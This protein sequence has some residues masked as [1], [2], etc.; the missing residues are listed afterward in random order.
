[1]NLPQ[2]PEPNPSATG[3]DRIRNIG[4]LAHVDAGKTS[5]TEKMLFLTGLKRETGAVDEGTTATDYLAV[6]R[7]HGIT[8]KSAAVRFDWK[9]RAIHLIDTPGHV[10]FGNEV[11]RALR[12]LDGAVIALCAVS[13]VQARTE[14]ISRA[15]AARM[16]PRLYFINKM[17]RSGAD[18]LGVV[19]DLRASLEPDTIAFQS[20]LFDGQKWVGFIDLISMKV[21]RFGATDAGLPF[22]QAEMPAASREAAL[23]ARALLLEKVAEADEE[24]LSLYASDR[25]ISPES[26]A[27]AAS[28]ATKA[29]RLV[30]VFCGSAFVDSSIAC[31]LDAVVAFLP[32]PAEASIPSGLDPGGNILPPMKATIAPPFAAFVF[33]T[34]RD[35]AGNNYAWAR[36]WSGTLH[37]GKKCFE[38]RSTKD[39]I[40]RKIFGIHAESLIELKEAGPGEVVALRTQG[41]ESGASLCERSFPIL[42]EALEIPVPVVSLVMEPASLEDV[43]AIRDALETL[44]LEDL[45]LRLSE[46]KETGRFEV[47]GQGELHLDIVAERLKR[48]F[49]LR[50]RTGNPRVNCRER[51]LRS[52]SVIEE[53]DHDFGGERIR[54]KMEVLVERRRRD[55][56]SEA[57]TEADNK[58]AFAPGLRIQPQFAAAAQRGAESAM[59]VGPS[60][61]WPMES[62][63]L[64]IATFMPP[65]SNTGRNGETAVEAAAALATRKAL[66]AGGSEILEPVMRIEIECP[67]EHFGPVLGL[68]TA[69]GGRIES[70]EDGI[71]IKN[72]SARAPMGRLFGFAGELRSMSKGRA[73]FQ[74]FFENYEPVKQPF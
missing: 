52:T 65:G 31:L 23:V 35:S 64:T 15:S 33:K 32:S 19:T 21:W 30:P 25:P 46:E 70:V 62:L 14:A 54:L 6:E 9:G 71:G 72:I 13:G 66:L 61:G 11:D 73:Q 1:M 3:M 38:A 43:A 26:L 47:S 49:G 42:F 40:I 53:F 8:V 74:A 5:I 34:L 39:V 67:E 29:C 58:V 4:V 12:I 27:R 16:L 51:L 50:I 7:L 63:L 44:A 22:E 45:S 28:A 2:S 57:N 36:I 10:D 24:I 69:R 37:A 68:V 56:H 18:F 48:E 60:Q 17:D 55:P 59:A 20:P 41:L